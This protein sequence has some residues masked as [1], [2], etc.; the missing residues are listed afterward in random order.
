MAIDSL[1][2]LINFLLHC[3]KTHPYK[4]FFA[5]IQDNSEKKSEKQPI[6]G[7]II[8]HILSYFK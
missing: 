4:V 7:I 6:F 2:L 8:P 3:S 5:K 1:I